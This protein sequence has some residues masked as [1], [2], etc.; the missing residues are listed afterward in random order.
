MANNEHQDLVIL[1]GGVG[2]LIIASVAGQLGLKVTLIEK[3]DR[4]GGDCLHYGCVPSKTLIHSA[5]VASLMRRGAEFGLPSL[6]TDVDLNR[7]MQH[8][9]DVIETIQKHDDPKRFHSY[10]CE[11]VFGRARFVDAHRVAVDGQNIAGRRFVIAT[12]SSAAVPPVDGI[13]RIGYL[14]N[15]TVFAHGRLPTQLLV[16]GGGPIGVELAQAFLRLGSRVVLVQRNKRLLPKEDPDITTAL[17]EQLVDEGME[18]HTDAAAQRIRRVDDGTLELKCSG[19]L[20]LTGD[21]LLL[22]SGRKPNIEGLDLDA[23][24]VVHDQRGIKVDAR[25]R[26]SQKHIFACGDVCGPFAF[27]HMAE[28]QAG[29]VISN[30]VFRW[31]KKVDYSVVP[32]VTY[33]DPEVARVGLNEMQAKTQNIDYEPLRFDFKDVDRALAEVAPCGHAKILIRKQR[34]LGATLIGPHAGELLHELILA[35]QAKIKIGQI[36]AAV[37][38]YPTL[39]QIVRRTVNTHYA[40]TLFSPRTRRLVAAINKLMP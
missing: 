27:T 1:G 39:A 33:T 36:S 10:G 30:A 6:A 20:A 5:K 25:L 12:G 4:L 29:I 32:W 7:V 24:G 35:M 11:V 40:K 15:E 22:A 21:T 2:G 8:V 38:V 26:T 19:E 34:I 17:Q 13:E 14:T 37:H 9:A 3:T 28:Y 18:I 31:P 23:A 16:L